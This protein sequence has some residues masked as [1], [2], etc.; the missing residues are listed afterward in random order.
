MI[1]VCHHAA[2]LALKYLEF[3]ENSAHRMQWDLANAGV[4]GVDIFFVISG[5]VM[6]AS[7]RRFDGGRDAIHF[8]AQRYNRIAPLFYLLSA[9]LLADMLRAQVPFDVR[10][11]L[12]TLTFVPWFDGREY[13]WP[14]HYLGWTLAFEF[15][16][17]G[18]VTALIW[19]G[20]GRRVVLLAAILAGLAL[21]GALYDAPWLPLRMLTSP[22]MVE[23]GLGGLA[24]RAWRAGWFDRRALRW[25]LFLVAGMALF[26][27]SIF[28]ELHLVHVMATD[29]LDHTGALRRLLWWGIP[30]FA[31]V[32]W[33]LTLTPGAD[34]W[35]RRGAR[36]IG[37]ASYSIYLTHLFVVRL[38]EE[39]IQRSD[40]PVVLVAVSVVIVSPVVGW[41]SYR[42]LEQPLLRSGQGWIR[43]YMM[44]LDG[45]PARGSL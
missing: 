29:V 9:L 6:A 19:S 2:L 38:A 36:L 17:Y 13:H 24:Y 18:V 15:V 28:G 32:C 16:F 42:L 30:A 21:A 40:L 1:V 4:F 20:G 14:I 45:S 39:V 26:L 37:D 12:N 35:P 11:V 43:Q 7:A 10:D 5:F 44:R 3:P 33:A 23:F 22:T 31:I 27:W 41:A 8:L 25:H 34:R